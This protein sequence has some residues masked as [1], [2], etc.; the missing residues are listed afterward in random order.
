MKDTS[1]KAMA[2]TVGVVAA[3]GVGMGV[4]A[5]LG[6]RR[7]KEGPPE[8]APAVATTTLHVL[9]SEGGGWAIRKK[10]ST[11]DVGTFPT[12]K[13]A[14]TAARAEADDHRPSTL[15][16]HGADGQIQRSHSYDVE[17]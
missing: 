1:K 17:E 6:R 4:K 8:A 15:V 2:A 10:G 7:S 16:V 5:A 9:P 14:M 3:A 12:K 11:E 13:E